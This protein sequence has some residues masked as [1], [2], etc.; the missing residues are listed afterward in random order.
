MSDCSDASYN[1][2]LLNFISTKLLPACLPPWIT[3]NQNVFNTC[4]DTDP[5]KLNKEMNKNW[6]KLCADLSDDHWPDLFKACSR[7]CTK[8]L[9]I[10]KK[11]RVISNLIDSQYTLSIHFIDPITVRKQALEY[12]FFDMMVEI[13]SSLGLWL[14]LSAID[15]LV[16]NFKFYEVVIHLWQTFLKAK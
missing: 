6:L 8:F 15:L 11:K 2:C 7:P 3:L 16:Y 14:G 5:F 13:G 10:L 12:G 1:A 4:S 9:Y